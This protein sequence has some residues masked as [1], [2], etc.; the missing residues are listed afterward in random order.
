MSNY[1]P[2]MLIY[3][4][5]ALLCRINRAV[6]CRKAVCGFMRAL[7]SGLGA[8]LVAWQLGCGEEE[9]VVARVGSSE[10]TRAQ[11]DAFI[12]RLPDGMRS[13]KEGRDALLE[14]LQAIVSQELLLQEIRHRGVDTSE[15]VTHKLGQLSRRRLVDRYQAQFVFPRVQ[16]A[17]EE[18]ERAFV[19]LGYDRERL[20]SR[21]LVRTSE[22]LDEVLGQLRDGTSF[23]DL[24]R[25]FAANDL[26]ARDG[27]GIVGWMGQL[28][29]RQL[30]IPQRVFSSLPVGQV[31]EPLRLPGGWQIYRFAEERK[32]EIAEYWEEVHRVLQR[33]ERKAEIQKE[34]E[35]LSRRYG[36]RLHTEVLQL[37][38]ER[39]GTRP[40]SALQ[41][42]AGEKGRAL[43]SFSEEKLTLGDY[44]ADL[45]AMG[46]TD[47]LH[48]SAHV[49]EF[50]KRV[51]LRSRLMVAAAREQGW[52]R[53]EAFA[54]WYERKRR[55][56]V[57]RQ[58]MA[59]E[60]AG[61]LQPG[62]AAVVA[63][64][65]R[66]KDRL[67]SPEQVEIREVSAQ[68]EEEGLELR[69]QIEAGTEILELLQRPGITSHGDRR[70]RGQMRLL[71]QHRARYPEMVDSAF[72]AAKGDLV[73]PVK[74]PYGYAVF[75]VLQ[76]SGGEIQSL[77]EV[78]DRVEGILRQRREGEL[79][80]A[81]IDSLRERDRDRVELFADGLH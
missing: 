40:L 63:Y 69:R 36:L 51:S 72:A 39:L 2:I 16:V 77:E 43:Y 7:L 26:Y 23:E 28:K 20:V 32:A 30:A 71:R 59:E 45:K 8:L 46:F 67:R 48:D 10:I 70:G 61:K 31:A 5:K 68:T 41:L 76:I 33:E 34:F 73:G 54:E 58:L 49:V 78:R 4:R 35:A 9:P 3:F 17:A 42:D 65:E 21:I 81:Y 56:L 37:L 64:Y 25:K 29:V 12:E 55:G 38:L 18:V 15:A 50:A 53:E 79:I 57:L 62:E 1:Y 11:L 6:S 52:E 60:T 47:V 22:E 80:E 19:D 75:R 14:H 74:T 13:K 66:E 24:A 27:D 44:V